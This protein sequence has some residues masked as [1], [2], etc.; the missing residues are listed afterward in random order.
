MNQLDAYTFSNYQPL[1]DIYGCQCMGPYCVN[2]KL[3][4]H[5]HENGKVLLPSSPITYKKCEYRGADTGWWLSN[6]N[7]NP[8]LP[9]KKRGI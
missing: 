9:L 3:C 7:K 5:V 8:G 6:L 4:I 2:C 1:G